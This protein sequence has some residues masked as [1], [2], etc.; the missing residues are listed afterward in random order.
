MLPPFSTSLFISIL[1]NRVQ[2]WTGQPASSIDPPFFLSS[3][4]A[5][6]RLQKAATLK[7]LMA[8]GHPLPPTSSSIPPQLPQ[9]CWPPPCPCAKPLHALNSPRS[10]LSSSHPQLPPS[11]LC[12]GHGSRSLTYV[13]PIPDRHPWA[14]SPRYPRICPMQPSSST[15]TIVVKLF[16]L[17]N[18]DALWQSLL[19]RKYVNN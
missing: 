8:W 9:L 16:M 12:A 17:I 6:A 7:L 19:R 2:A 13:H 14:P 4:L 15:I 1:G 5:A 11:S 18:E 3:I 10:R